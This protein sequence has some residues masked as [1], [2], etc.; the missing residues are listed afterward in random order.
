MVY[1]HTGEQQ[2]LTKH[3]VVYLATTSGT[4]GKNKL[5]PVTQWMKTEPKLKY[6]S[7]IYYVTSRCAGLDLQ[8]VFVLSYSA[9]TERSP[10]G[11]LKGP[12][13]QHMYKYP[14]FILAPRSVYSLTNEQLALHVHAVFALRDA[15]VGRI[16]A[17]MSTLVY[18]FWVY[19]EQHWSVV[20]DDIERGTL[21]INHVCHDERDNE[22]TVT[23]DDESIAQELTKLL[24][25][26]A[27]RAAQLRDEFASGFDNISLRVWPNLSSVR[28]LTSG[29][30]ALA[31]SRLRARYMRGV[32]QLS[33]VHAASEGF[34]GINTTPE[35]DSPVYTVTIDS[36]VVEFIPESCTHDDEPATLSIQEVGKTQRHDAKLMTLYVSS[37]T[38]KLWNCLWELSNSL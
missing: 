16:E 26:N 27:K 9:R 2:L 17:L 20:C 23:Q 21:S 10:C 4:T 18:S 36:T 7:I 19:V 33:L 11:L 37:S 30:F 12:I 28:M 22:S 29:G 13:S 31:A 38:V 3:D 14:P 25:P 5:F 15:D 35:L 32:K 34:M 8:R 6:G 1:I 24:T